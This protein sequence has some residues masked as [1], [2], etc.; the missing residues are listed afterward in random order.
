MIRSIKT[1]KALKG[2]Q[3]NPPTDIEAVKLS[4]L[5]LSQ[6]F[7]NHPEISELDIN[8]LIVYPEGKGCMVAD[9]PIPRVNRCNSCKIFYIKACTLV[10][11]RCRLPLNIEK[12]KHGFSYILTS[13]N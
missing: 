13:K 8:P 12:I 5:W 10:V 9:G 6:M 1:Y 2:V 3:G 4:I 11:M 7:V